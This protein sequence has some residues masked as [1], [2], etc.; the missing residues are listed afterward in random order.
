M[1]TEISPEMEMVR[2]FIASH[3]GVQNEL[4]RKIL[5]WL[6]EQTND[7]MEPARTFVPENAFGI[8]GFID[9]FQPFDER[10]N[11]INMILA[12]NHIPVRYV[13]RKIGKGL[14]VA[15]LP[16]GTTVANTSSFDLPVKEFFERM[17]LPTLA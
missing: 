2:V 10:R 7:F 17:V 5:V 14:C 8:E 4:V 13:A 16:P 11:G 1:E 6:V 9:M 12:V 15:I 3:P